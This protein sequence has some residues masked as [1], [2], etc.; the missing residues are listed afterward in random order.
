M[1]PGQLHYIGNRLPYG[2]RP[3]KM[4]CIIKTIYKKSLY[5][6]QKYGGCAACDNADLQDQPDTRPR[7]PKS[8][9]SSLHSP[10]PQCP[11]QS[12]RDSAAGWKGM[13]LSL[14]P[15]PPLKIPFFPPDAVLVI[16]VS[17][18]PAPACVSSA[19]CIIFIV[20]GVEVLKRTCCSWV[21]A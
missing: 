10:T 9:S 17:F 20:L 15:L 13:D 7:F 11:G 1:G 14:S 2:T 5:P 21:K 6:V 16:S 3:I 8:G 12:G 18:Q 4:K 19:C